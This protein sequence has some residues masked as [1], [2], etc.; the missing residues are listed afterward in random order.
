MKKH[1]C[2]DHYVAQLL[3]QLEDTFKEAQAQ[4]T[5]EAE[6]QKSYYDRKANDILLELCDLVLAKANAYME[7][8]KVKDQWEEEL[9]E[10]KCQVAKGI[11]YYLMKNSRWMFMSPPLKLTFSDHSQKW[12][13]P[14]CMVVLIEWARCATTNLEEQ[15]LKESETK[16]VPQSVNCLP[17]AHTRQMT[18]L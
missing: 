12:G 5:S 9:Y 3:E 8:W 6:R 2:V 14:L 11:P 1:Q 4:S 10:V 17:Q 16:E 13:P 18:L 7:K 15:T